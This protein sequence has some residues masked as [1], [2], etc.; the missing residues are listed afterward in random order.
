MLSPQKFYPVCRYTFSS[1]FILSPVSTP[2]LLPSLPFFSLPFFSL[3]QEN[4]QNMKQFECGTDQSNQATQ[5][6]QHVSSRRTNTKDAPAS[7]K[8][9]IHSILGWMLCVTSV[10]LAWPEC[11]N[12]AVYCSLESAGHA[13]QS[14]KIACGTLSAAI[15]NA[16]LANWISA[17]VTTEYFERSAF[18]N[19]V[20][21]IFEPHHSIL[22]KKFYEVCVYKASCQSI[23]SCRVTRAIWSWFSH[24]RWTRFISPFRV[25]ARIRRIRVI[26]QELNF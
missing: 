10:L 11:F 15:F 13:K 19:D 26:M 1:C 16:S 21:A 20:N 9:C 22:A 4:T 2:P 17:E 12:T 24:T 6:A 18:S 23:E 7:A 14:A 3:P 25:T 5:S 8:L